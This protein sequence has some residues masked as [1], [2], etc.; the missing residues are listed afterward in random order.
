MGYTC[1]LNILCYRRGEAGY[2]CLN[3]VWLSIC[4]CGMKVSCGNR[5][6]KNIDARTSND[7]VVYIFIIVV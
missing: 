1:I 7:T 5:R 2:W 4:S 3:R 6:S